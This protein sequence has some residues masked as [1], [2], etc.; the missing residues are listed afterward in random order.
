MTMR[1]T[2][3]GPRR[4]TTL[5]A[6]LLG[7]TLAGC[8][9][10]KPTPADTTPP[11]VPTSLQATEVS[12][13][14]V[15]L[16]WTASTDDRKLL[17][18]EVYQDGTLVKEAISAT[19]A[20]I[21]GLTPSTTYSFTVKARDAAKNASPS[22]APLSV[23]TSKP[24]DTT[25]P[26]VPTDL[27]AAG[28]G[29]TVVS[30][31]WTASTD[32]GATV[33]YDVYQ[34]GILVQSVIDTAAAVISGLKFNTTYAFTVKARDAASNVSAAS[35]PLSVTTTNGPDTTPPTVP[36][37]LR[38]VGVSDT[39]VILAWAASA[40]DRN[41]VI[42]DVYQND[43]LVRTVVG[44]T[45]VTLSG[46][47]P[48][49]AYAFTV[50]ARDAVNNISEAS[51]PLSVT[52][53][54]SNFNLAITKIGS[55]TLSPQRGT[56][57]CAP[58]TLVTVA[59]TPAAGYS[60]AGWSG[61]A[62]GTTS[63]VTVTVD[64]SKT[65]TATFTLTNPDRG[66]SINVGG[67][68]VGNFLADIYSSGGATYTNRNTID[69]SSIPD[70]VP[71]DVIFQSER[72][73]DSTYTIPNR[74]PGSA[75]VVTLYFAET[76]LSSAGQRTFDVII[77]GA[78]AL[79]G[80][81]IFA[82]AGA[83]NKGVS[84]T[85]N[86]N[87]DSSG[88][89]VIQ[90]AKNGGKDNPKVCGITVVGDTAVTYPLTVSK[91]GTGAGTVSGAGIDC[92]STCSAGFPSGASVTLTATPGQDGSTFGGWSGA[93]SG[94]GACT[95][96]MTAATTVTATFTNSTPPSYLVSMVQSS[97]AQAT[98]ITTAEVADLVSSAI[99]QAGGLDFIHDGQTV[100]LKPN[101]LT[102]YTDGGSTRADQAVNG[103]DTDWRVTKAVADLVRAR[104]PNGKILVMEG[105]VAP[106]AT[107]FSI[108]G[109]TTANFGSS[110]DEFI[111][112]EGSSCNDTS[113]SALVQRT[114]L[115]GKT[116]WV[117]SRYANADVVISLPAMKTHLMAGVTGA[118]KNLGIGM[119]PVGKYS[120]G[121]AS[122]DCTR[123]QTA[124]YID[125]SSAEAL[126]Q[127]IRDYF[128][129]RPA[130][131]VVM[132]ALQGLEHG[133]LPYWD[134]S[135]T[136][137]YKPSRK[138]M[139]LILAGR[140]AV[141]VDT[142]ASLVMK[143][144]PRK[145]PYLTKLEADGLGTADVS[146][147]T[148]VGKQ[149]SEVARAFAGKLTNIC[150]GPS[151]LTI[152]ASG[153]GTTNPAPGTYPYE[154]GTPVTVTATPGAGATFQGW[155]GASTDTASS[156][157]VTVDGNKTLN[158][159]F[160]GVATRT[161][162]ACQVGQFYPAPALT[163]SAS[164]I[165]APSGSVASGTFE[166]PVWLAASSTLLF[167]DLSFTGAVNPS[168][169][170]ML[171]Q[172]NT[173]TSLLADAG[174]NGM[175]VDGSGTVYAASHA[176]QGIVRFDSTAGTFT[177]V[178]D[179]IGGK[180][181]NSP[182]DLVVRSDGTIYF[183]DPDFQLGSRTSATGVKGVYRVSPS[184]TVLLIDGTFGEPNGITL[185]PDEQVL[186]VADYSAN[187]VRAFNVAADGSTKDRRDWA[188][189]PSPDGFA[190]DCLGN[191]YVAS[192]SQ[193]TV[194]V[195]TPSG[196]KLGSIPVSAS[197]SNLAFGGANGQSLFVTAGKALYLFDLNLPGYNY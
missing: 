39:L 155:S 143:C 88:Q 56:Y 17:T 120:A 96:S 193:G 179:N 36:A 161:G 113:T 119:T 41:L 21:S 30:L 24:P 18:Y 9:D 45:T 181:F 114:A 16:S 91:S 29:D 64:A 5:S 89:V 38:A 71:P 42:Y 177:T 31:T 7:A 103:I 58:G 149:V 194:E 106:T 98:D 76:Y 176:V 170:F 187:V 126:G 4:F 110:V 127:F 54:A 80:F 60:F 63:P 168:Q 164:L 189:V 66:V 195:F 180:K 112:V 178:V 136:Y 70:P 196:I 129:V 166:G 14:S 182:N 109:Y 28:V 171:Q 20:T 3:I 153:S 53:S 48:K 191:L 33:I 50:K 137:D 144:D 162:G 165:Y 65:L 154:P 11:T 6:L 146:K 84:R 152:T 61:A 47:T 132:D 25:P 22:S 81:D 68:A 157:T 159:T 128:S 108:L 174:V 49:T 124:A 192:G 32:D 1:T 95:V 116:Y 102:P 151:T 10:Q 145:V 52:T 184:G 133:P 34:D 107:A 141:A 46:L 40:D 19:S 79:S 86:T 172:P 115:S 131:F 75:Q 122:T 77:N 23:T 160:L 97:Q 87:A 125:H 44:T 142:I 185:S 158:A 138:N 186:Y 78:T 57:S 82:A 26:T 197:V 169:L 173:V 93:C 139:R 135:G 117:N 130:D 140:N 73:N 51:A 163:G 55:G 94:A 72:Y 101:L 15:S 69:T 121:N 90:F 104:N 43:L 83:A 2:M 92:G 190:V 175:A 74:A 148:V 62:T 59:A 12:V 167:S 188:S 37:D 13:S 111:A 183:T 27:H 147:I 134:N 156:I 118:V 85:F 123:G 100:V 99:T 67:P 150:P 35:E 8:G 105:S